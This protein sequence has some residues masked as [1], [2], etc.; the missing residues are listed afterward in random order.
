MLSGRN[1]LPAARKMNAV[2][3]IPGFSTYGCGRTGMLP[4]GPALCRPSTSFGAAKEDVDARDKPA[5]DDLE[6]FSS[7]SRLVARTEKTLPGQTCAK[8]GTAI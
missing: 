5:H 3:L 2:E 1:L 4:G 7:R 6:L 8:A